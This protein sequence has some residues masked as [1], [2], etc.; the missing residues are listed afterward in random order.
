MPEGESKE[1]TIRSLNARVMV[2]VAKK[3]W[4]K[5]KHQMADQTSAGLVAAQAM[6]TALGLPEGPVKDVEVPKAE[7]AEEEA[8]A[9]EAEVLSWVWRRNT[10]LTRI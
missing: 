8:D 6:A 7:A 10:Y 1:L 5:A 9:R 2:L 3:G 4:A